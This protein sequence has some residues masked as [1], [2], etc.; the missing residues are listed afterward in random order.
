MTGE[1]VIVRVLVVDDEETVR[2]LLQRVMKEEGYDVVTASNGQE[3]LDAI[4]KDP[5]DILI[6]DL[7]MPKI[8]GLTLLRKA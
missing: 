7:K 3:A 5:P 2:G 4:T 8:D 1:Q 6:S